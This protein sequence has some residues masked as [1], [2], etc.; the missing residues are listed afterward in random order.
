[1]ILLDTLVIPQV[2]TAPEAIAWW[3]AATPDAPALFGVSGDAMSFAELQSRIEHFARQLATLGIKRGDRVVL[4]L[5]DGVAAAVAGLAT[6]R[7]AVGVPVNPAQSRAEANPILAS[8]AP[9]VVIVAQGAETAWR[10]AA[11]HVNIPVVA[12][13]DVGFLLLDVNT[14]VIPADLPLLPAPDDLAEILLTSGTT[15]VPRRVPATHRNMLATCSARVR[16]RCLTH[17]DRGLSTAPAYFVLGLA[18]IIE[19]LISGGSTILAT[20]NEITRQPDAI[21]TLAP[22]WAWI[23]PALLETV[24]E[25]ARQDPTYREWPLRFVRSGGAQVTPELIARAQALWGVPVLN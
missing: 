8:V 20:A 21:R 2:G 25:A 7:T 5:P 23:G 3:A 24:L 18:R 10:D 15:D 11:L 19:A 4:A 17:R 14:S 22:T 13:N 16:V 1:M 9:R 6:I 12:L